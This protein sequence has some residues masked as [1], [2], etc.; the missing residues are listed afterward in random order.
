MSSVKGKEK[1]TSITIINN[2]IENKI[3]MKN[4]T[5]IISNMQSTEEKYNPFN[6]LSLYPK[7]YLKKI[8][9][10]RL[11][12]GNPP[13]KGNAWSKICFSNKSYDFPQDIWKEIMSF[14]PTNYAVDVGNCYSSLYGCIRMI[15]KR[16]KKQIRYVELRTN[17]VFNYKVID[18]YFQHI[19]QHINPRLSV[20]DV[21]WREKEKL[22][23]YFMDEYN[24]PK[25][26]LMK[27]PYRGNDQYRDFENRTIELKDIKEKDKEM[28]IQYLILKEKGGGDAKPNGKLYHNQ[29]II[30]SIK[31]K[32]LVYKRKK[33]YDPPKPYPPNTYPKQGFKKKDMIHKLKASIIKVHHLL[34]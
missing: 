4:P 8:K 31:N 29:L 5:I 26:F 11:N 1:E 25:H 30:K 16:T 22:Y 28:Y 24:I 27:Q 9:K 18:G 19:P 13:L 21:V 17:I 33:N 7:N 12:G 20:N 2:N 3:E 6:D 15:T 23:Y 10:Q 34:I 32:E 14:M